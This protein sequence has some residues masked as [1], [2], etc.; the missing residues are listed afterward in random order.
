MLG[1]RAGT[2]AVGGPCGLASEDHRGARVSLAGGGGH[3]QGK[4]P[5][6]SSQGDCDRGQGRPLSSNA[7][8]M[9][10]KKE[11]RQTQG[12]G[13]SVHPRASPVSAGPCGPEAAVR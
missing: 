13:G 2:A 7:L 6:A 3:P 11:R 1:E 8:E 4:E 10:R 9:L 12:E 5:Q